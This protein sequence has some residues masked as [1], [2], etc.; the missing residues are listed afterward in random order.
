MST[1]VEDR[2]NLILNTHSVVRAVVR[3]RFLATRV[4]FP[5]YS[6]PLPLTRAKSA[7]REHFL[8]TPDLSRA[9]LAPRIGVV[10]RRK[11]HR[12]IHVRRGFGLPAGK[13]IVNYVP[14]AVNVLAEAKIGPSNAFPEHTP[15]KK[16]KET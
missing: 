14:S 11:L 12:Q 5:A 6:A 3:R 10:R 2:Q 13:P 9:R 16:V 7:R 4:G 8:P 1:S 15:T